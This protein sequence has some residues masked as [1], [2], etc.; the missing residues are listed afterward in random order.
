[1]SLMTAQQI[2]E[3]LLNV[4]LPY[5][6]FSIYLR[7]SIYVHKTLLLDLQPSIYRIDEERKFA[8][9][10]EVRIGGSLDLSFVE[11][12]THLSKNIAGL[13]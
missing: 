9:A 10:I 1:M 5:I 2:I 11:L 8:A 7:L 4:S 12:D 6:V 3:E 13:V